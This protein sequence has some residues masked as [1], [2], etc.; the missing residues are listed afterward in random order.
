M[1]E[2][3]LVVYRPLAQ[4]GDAYEEPHGMCV[5]YAR[6]GESGDPRE[7]LAAIF[8]FMRTLE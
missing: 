1:W 2:R 4:D 7:G 5:G 3:G 8:A 6:S